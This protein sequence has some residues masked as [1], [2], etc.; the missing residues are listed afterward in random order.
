MRIILSLATLVAVTIADGRTPAQSDEI[1][2]HETDAKSYH[3]FVERKLRYTYPATAMRM[4]RECGNI[5]DGICIDIGCGTGRLDV[6]L[7]KRSN[8]EIIGLDIDLEMKPFFEKHVREAGF[9]DR[10]RFVAGDA[11][12]LPFPDDYADIVVSRGA[13]IFI[14]DLAKCLT[15]VDRVLKPTGV[16]FLGGRY[17]YAPREKKIPSPDLRRIVHDSGVKGAEVIE[18]RGQWVKI[19]GPMAAEAAR[20]PKLGPSMLAARCLADYGIMRGDCLLICGSDGELVRA[21]Q[22]GFLDMTEFRITALYPQE[23]VAAQARSRIRAAQQDRRITCRVGK[24]ETLPF[25]A[26]SYDLVAGVGPMLIWSDRQKAMRELYRI[27]RPGGCALIGGRYIHMPANRKVSSET[28][29]EDAQATG[30]PSIRILDDMGQWIEI[31]KE[32]EEKKTGE[33]G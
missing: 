22:H 7:A 21:L 25:A 12:K 2:A 27:L 24:I 28:L 13:L 17:L 31:R 16:A 4:L 3:E 29:R 19:I 8:L 6:E 10:I 1:P 23:E 11:Q 30:I 5:Q 15:E 20:K 14:P 26:A 32:A 18:G 33:D 9:E